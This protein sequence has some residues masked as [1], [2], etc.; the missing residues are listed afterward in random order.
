MSV[1]EIILGIVIVVLSCLIVG[2]SLLIKH[3]KGGL[4]AAISGGSVTM[5]SNKNNAPEKKINRLICSMSIAE[6]ICILAMAV[7]SAHV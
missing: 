3:N 1:I 5:D 7:L 4:S 6:G 2:A